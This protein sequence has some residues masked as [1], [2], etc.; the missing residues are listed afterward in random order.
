MTTPIVRVRDLDV[1][2]R[3]GQGD[4]FALQGAS[5]EVGPTEIVGV[6]GES[7]SGKSTL[8]R[9]LM[10]MLPRGSS[11]IA[12]GS[13]DIDGDDVTHLG[14]KEWE[15]YRGQPVAIVFQ[16]PL[17]YLNPVMRV[18]RQI[19]EGIRKRGRDIEVSRRV[20]ELLDL[21]RLPRSTAKAYPHELSGGMRQR[22]LLAIAL[23]CRPRLLIAD[24]PTTALDV[25]TQ[26]EIITLLRDI[27]ASLDVS[28]LIISH[29][30]AVIADLCDR[31]YVMYG[32][33]VVE[34]GPSSLVLSVPGHPY[35]YG[36]RQAAATARGDDGRFRTIPGEVASLSV[37]SSG[38]PFV[39]R[40]PVAVAR[41]WIEMPPAFVVA[42]HAAHQA[43]CWLVGGPH[44][45]ST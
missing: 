43:R 40:C 24:E 16:D 37:R 42:G 14:P 25:T 41:C 4:V 20:T 31:I 3:T 36:L 39:E 7:G 19:E 23:G 38:C 10:G 33:R 12:G 30:L 28:I 6:V 1:T 45:T 13:I 32:G 29:N 26:A 17:S 35:T 2:Y 8:A 5:L 22:V 18:D 15:A 11:E 21:V 27:Q 34:W 44:G 9:A